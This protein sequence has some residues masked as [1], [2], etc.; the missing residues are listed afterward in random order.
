M[1]LLRKLDHDLSI[2][3]FQG[4]TLGGNEGHFLAHLGKA[5][6]GYMMTRVEIIR[7]Y[8]YIYYMYYNYKVY[9]KPTCGFSWIMSKYT[10]GKLQSTSF[11]WKWT[12][13]SLDRVIADSYLY[14][15]LGCIIYT[16]I[17]FSNLMYGWRNTNMIWPYGLQNPEIHQNLLKGRDFG[18]ETLLIFRP[19]KSI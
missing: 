7:T 16:I 2:N 5:S 17:Y 4:I 12:L 19:P 14:I 13:D 10:L 15:F 11:P 3:I 9:P 6:G 8:T 1:T 18:K